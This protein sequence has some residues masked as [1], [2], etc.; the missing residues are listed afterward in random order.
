[1]SPHYLCLKRDIPDGT[2]KSFDI[3]HL[4]IVVKNDSGV[5]TISR[6]ECKH[7]G[8]RVCD[9]TGPIKN[10]NCPYH[11][12]RFTFPSDYKITENG[13]ALFLD[14]PTDKFLRF[15]TLGEEFGQHTLRVK[16]PFHLW[17]QNTMDPNHLKT[18][19]KTGFAKLFKNAAPFDVQKYDECSSYK[20]SLTDEVILKYN[21]FKTE[22]H[23]LFDNFMHIAYFPYLSVTSFMNIFLSV[24]TAV[25]DRED[26]NFTNVQTRFFVS[27]GSSVPELLRSMALKS[28]I[29]ILK[30]DKDIV[31]SWAN[32][33]YGGTILEE[34]RMTGEE[35][36]V[37][38]LDYLDQN[39][40]FS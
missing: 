11:G 12:K 3:F 40:L 32:Q 38:Y 1:M 7:R 13:E 36:L 39:G 16:A 31:E 18:V 4:N 27:P 34:E 15:P 10:I 19:H 33:Y 17:I 5:F 22:S 37:H 14:K 26:E 28:N 9:E 23:N 30:E 35:R 24:E 8:F 29:E 6:N 20:M 21:K 25:P 2:Y